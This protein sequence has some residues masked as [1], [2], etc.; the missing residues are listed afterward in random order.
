MDGIEKQINPGTPAPA[1]YEEGN[2]IECLPG[3][4][5]E[6]IGYMA[7]DSFAESV[8]GKEF[9]SIYLNEKANEWNEYMTQVSDWEIGK[10]LY[11]I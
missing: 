9:V 4:L 1:C 8:L 3:T 5:R 10:Y 6:A 11:R 7:E 2:Q